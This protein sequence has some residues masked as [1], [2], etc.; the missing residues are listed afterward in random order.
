MA[1]HDDFFTAGLKF[2][3]HERASDH[4]VNAKTAKEAGGRLKTARR[5]HAVAVHQV[6]CPKRRGDAV[7]HDIVECF[8]IDGRHAT[9]LVRAWWSV[10]HVVNAMSGW[11]GERSKQ[12]RVDDT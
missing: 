8:P 11:I 1:D 12:V 5:R 6:K 3:L 10:P 2:F 7:F 4:R 9:R